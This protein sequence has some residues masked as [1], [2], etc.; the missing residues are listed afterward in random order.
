M[1]LL[2]QVSDDY[3]YEQANQLMLAL[4]EA[5]AG[6][7]LAIFTQAL[8]HFDQDQRTTWTVGSDD[9]GTMIVRFWRQ[10]PAPL[11]LDAV[12]Q[13]LRKAKLRRTSDGMQFTM[14]SGSNRVSFG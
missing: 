6:D 7:R 10:L 4:P 8:R 12:D 3:P 13:L 11:V 14:S 5:R 9:F 2:N 1:D